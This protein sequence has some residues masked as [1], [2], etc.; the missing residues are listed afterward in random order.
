MES[1]KSP[2]DGKTI[3]AV[4]DEPDVLDTIAE[5]LHMCTIDK[6]T[7]FE[8]AFE[9]ILKNS[10]DAVILDIM[11][12]KYLEMNVKALAKRGRMVVIGLQGG[13]KGTLNLGL[14]L[15]KMGSIHATS[16]RFRSVA[17][18]SDICTR[19]A[20]VVWPMIDEGMIRTSPETRIPFDEVQRAHALLESGDNVGKIILTH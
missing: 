10:Y 6:A 18:K 7:D 19:V 17:E 2:L 20:E 13:V 8:T 5:L 14:L 1:V 12:A 3:L 15:Q 9:M 16:L 11:G 4:D